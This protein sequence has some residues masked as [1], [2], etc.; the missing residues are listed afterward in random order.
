[1]PEQPGLV[2]VLV[3]EELLNMSTFIALEEAVH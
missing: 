1:V 2:L 3:L